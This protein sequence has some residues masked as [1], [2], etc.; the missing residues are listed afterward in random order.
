MGHI[1]V[2]ISA[3]DCERIRKQITEA[4]NKYS[5]QKWSKAG[6]KTKTE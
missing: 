6:S 3:L 2:V 1:S 5:R 4:D